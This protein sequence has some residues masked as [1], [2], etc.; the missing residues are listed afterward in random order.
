MAKKTKKNPKEEHARLLFTRDGITSFKELSERTGA[1]AKTISG[2]CKAGNWDKFRQNILL[3]RDEQMQNLLAELTELNEAIK[4][5]KAGSRYAD[6]KEAD[7][8]RKLIR[9]IKDLS[10]KASVAEVIEACI[11][12]V[13]WVSISDL[14]KA[15]ELTGLFDAY[16]KDCL[17]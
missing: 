9:D 13:K 2:W 6:S 14:D 11:R 3:T 7:I 8:R 12:I 10:T 15:K 16:I 17:K 5:K 1:T 4:L